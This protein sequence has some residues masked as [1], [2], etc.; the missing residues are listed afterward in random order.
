MQG[1]VEGVAI[2]MVVEVFDFH[3]MH[4]L[5]Q[6][7]LRHCRTLAFFDDAVI[8]ADAYPASL[9]LVQ[10]E[11]VTR[12][13]RH[14]QLSDPIDAEALARQTLAAAP[15]PSGGIAAVAAEMDPGRFVGIDVVGIETIRRNS[16]IRIKSFTPGIVQ[17]TIF[18]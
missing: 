18:R 15:P 6:F 5:A 14:M 7:N 9:G 12:R 1:E 13:L 3:D 4:P 8:N 16:A 10:G 17:G 11:L 2:G